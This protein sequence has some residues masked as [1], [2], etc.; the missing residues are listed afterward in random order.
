MRDLS[1]LVLIL[2][3]L[4]ARP[5]PAQEPPEPPVA[6]PLERLTL[7]RTQRALER[8]GFVCEADSRAPSRSE[9]AFTCGARGTDVQSYQAWMVG[10]KDGSLLAL[11]VNVRRLKAGALSVGHA[12]QVLGSVARLPFTREQENERRDL[13]DWLDAHL[14]AP[15]EVQGHAE[16]SVNAR[17]GTM[18][19]A[20]PFEAGGVVFTIVG[21]P[22]SP[23][24]DLALKGY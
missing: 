7:E 11:T 18:D 12:L 3:V 19:L 1:G 24:I 21:M 20:P 17:S 8:L 14:R 10:D 15:L 9:V 23:G 4:V 13:Q 6:V 2:S 22:D 5:A 16:S